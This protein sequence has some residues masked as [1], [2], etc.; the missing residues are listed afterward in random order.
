MGNHDHMM[1]LVRRTVFVLLLLLS[2]SELPAG[3]GSP[4]NDQKILYPADA[5]VINIRAE[6]YSARGDGATDD[7]EAIQRAIRDHIKGGILYFPDGVYLV[8]ATLIWQKKDSKGAESWGNFTIQGQSAAGTIIRLKDQ[9]FTDPA[10]PKAIM[11]CGFFGSADWFHNYVK[12]ITFDIG[13]GNPGAVGLQFYSNNTGA[14]RDVNITSRDGLGL[15]GLDLGHHDMNGPLLV[16]NTR[17]KGFRVGVSTAHS[18]NSQTFEHLLV[19]DSAECGFSNDGQSVSIRKLSVVGAPVA[20]R[21]RGHGFMVLLESDLT[22]GR[23]SNS[24][25]VDSSAPLF[26]R[27]LTTKGFAAAVHSTRGH[28]PDGRSVKEFVSEPVLDLFPS[29]AKSL[30]L[31]IKEAPEPPDDPVE[32]WV[33]VL[34]FHEGGED[35]SPA[36]QAAIDSGATT[37]YFPYGTYKFGATVEV[38]GRVRRLVGLNS[39][40]AESTGKQPDS[41]PRFR[42]VEGTAP[43]VTFD[44][45]RAGFGG[46]VFIE[47]A[48]NRDLLIRECDGIPCV[49][50]GT[51]DIFMEDTTASPHGGFL[52]EGRARLWGRQFNLENFVNEK[53]PATLDNRGAQVWIL[54]LKTEQGNRLVATRKGGKTEILGGLVYTVTPHE[55]RPGFIVENADLSLSVLERCFM[56]RPMNP[57]VQETLGGQ[58]KALGPN[59][60]IGLY[61]SGKR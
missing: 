38:R 4:V 54:G 34:K 15:I 31:P 42:V 9:T 45:F 41:A 1:A 39:W 30:R 53:I 48:S 6:P 51:G 18:V 5:G 25:A 58:T 17:I 14:V 37:V 10:K 52:I 2:L 8:S 11:F 44:N 16:K 43:L 28:A 24:A 32:Q 60:V 59:S 40:F 27:D 7:T 35:F 46:R 55:G 47:Q 29:K 22:A 57:V 19:E 49:F 13:R 20:V 56:G 12:N 33:S 3:G 26:L 21:N 23:S 36:I 50:R 61:V